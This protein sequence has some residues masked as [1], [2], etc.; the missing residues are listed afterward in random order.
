MSKIALS[1]Y[2]QSTACTIGFVNENGQ[3]LGSESR[4]GLM[5]ASGALIEWC[6]ELQAKFSVDCIHCVGVVT[7]SV[8]ITEQF[9]DELAAHFQLSIKVSRPGLALANYERLWG[10]VPEENN[11]MAISIHSG[12]D[13]GVVLN[14]QE[15][16]GQGGLAGNISHLLVHENGQACPLGSYFSA[17]GIR[18]VAL[19]V[20]ATE[21]G[22]SPLRLVPS[23]E[24]TAN[25]IIE[26]A[27]AQDKLA[28]RVIQQLGEV[29]GLKLSDMINYFSPKYFIISSF[30]K[31][32]SDLLVKAA[33]AKMEASVF[34]VFKGKV[35]VLTSKSQGDQYLSLQAAAAAF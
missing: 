10:H 24:L 19:S 4:A 33:S 27:M 18:N 8:T 14:G 26:A 34:P 17:V 22:G 12:I 25:T 20:M 13:G 30:S 23:N 11:F 29:L 2:L 1:V 32:F 15:A 9:V 21:K 7:D 35:T 28:L 6:E 5:T 3:C 16:K 31:Q